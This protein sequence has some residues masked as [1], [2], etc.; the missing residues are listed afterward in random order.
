[1]PW[2]Q[3]KTTWETTDLFTLTDWQRIVSNA[4][5]LYDLIGATFTWQACALSSTME[6][7]YYDIV[8]ALESN[9]YNL[10]V[11][12]Q[13]NSAVFNQVEWFARTSQYWTHNPSAEDFNRWEYLEAQLYYLH[14][15]YT[16]QT[17]QIVAGTFYAST[18]RTTQTFARGR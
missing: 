9:L 6:L 8:N 13:Y 3:P 10:C 1:M 18:N 4:E 5:Y 12:A 15:I 2:V 11:T 17:N 16:T 7:P 14:N